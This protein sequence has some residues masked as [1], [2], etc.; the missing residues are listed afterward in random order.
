M[1]GQGRS[2]PAL[3]NSTVH[4][5]GPVKSETSE[6]FCKRCGTSLWHGETMW[7]DGDKVLV[8]GK[9]QIRCANIVPADCKPREGEQEMD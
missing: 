7:R 9:I 3:P 2:F 8:Q 4:V 1:N 6:Q 5:A